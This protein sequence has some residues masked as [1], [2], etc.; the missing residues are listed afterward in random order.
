M[1]NLTALSL[2]LPGTP[3]YGLNDFDPRSRSTSAPLRTGFGS[4]PV[5]SADAWR[6]PPRAPRG[7]RWALRARRPLPARV[8][9]SASADLAA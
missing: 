8:P 6:R 1:H 9:A 3:L 5:A 4:H 2:G 7:R